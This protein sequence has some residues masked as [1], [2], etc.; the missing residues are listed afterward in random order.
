MNSR[1]RRIRVPAS[2]LKD[3]LGNRPRDPRVTYTTG[4]A[5]GKT[6]PVVGKR[7][8]ERVQRRHQRALALAA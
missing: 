8:R 5:K 2:A 1:S 7:Q 4:I 6:Y 3:Y